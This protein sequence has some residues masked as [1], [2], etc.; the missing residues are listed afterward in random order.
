MINIIFVYLLA[1]LIMGIIIDVNLIYRCPDRGCRLFTS[2][3]LSIIPVIN[4][5][6]VRGSFEIY[7]QSKLGYEENKGDYND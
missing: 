2:V 4:I 3:M 1:S 7:K 5:I 6:V